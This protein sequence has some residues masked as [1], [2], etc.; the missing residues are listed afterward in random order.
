M[1]I[2]Q[3]QHSVSRQLHVSSVIEEPKHNKKLKTNIMVGYAYSYSF[4]PH[5]GMGL[6]SIEPYK[7]LMQ[8]GIKSWFHVIPF[9]SPVSQVMPP[10]ACNLLCLGFTSIN[11][12]QDNSPDIAIDHLKNSQIL[13]LSVIV[14]NLFDLMDFKLV[15]K[16]NQEKNI[17]IF[18]T[19]HG[20]AYILTGVDDLLYKHLVKFAGT[21]KTR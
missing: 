11:A 5:S 8:I 9:L 12:H 20:F 13:G 21:Q 16:N 19:E 17:K 10:N 1:D 7:N 14:I 3:S 6:R 15:D 4:L 2:T 18:K